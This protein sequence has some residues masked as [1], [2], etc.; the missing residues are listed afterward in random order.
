MRTSPNLSSTPS[1]PHPNLSRRFA[2]RRELLLG[3]SWLWTLGFMSGVVC[4]YLHILDRAAFRHPLYLQSFGWLSVVGLAFQV[5]GR[6]GRLG[7][8]V[9]GARCRLVGGEAAA[10]LSSLAEP[11]AG[12]APPPTP[13]A[14]SIHRSC[15]SAGRRWW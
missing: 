9:R 12:W 1:R 2:A 11:G 5:R 14:P 8:I 4:N 13:T 6:G 15:A 10:R 7:G 3:A